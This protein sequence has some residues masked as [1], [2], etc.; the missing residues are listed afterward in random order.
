MRV[1][2]NE[3]D[4]QKIY[5][6][7]KS[8]DIKNEVFFKN[9]VTKKKYVCLYM[10]ERSYNSKY[11]FLKKR[12]DVIWYNINDFKEG[13]YSLINKNLNII[14]LSLQNSESKSLKINI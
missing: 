12:D 13:I 6:Q 3:G 14:D 9:S 2:L 7:R 10:R 4:F 5:L 8:F 11:S 1:L